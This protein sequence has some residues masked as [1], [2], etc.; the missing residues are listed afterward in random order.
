MREAIFENTKV[1]LTSDKAQ[2]IAEGR[3]VVFEGHLKVFDK[4]EEEKVLPAL[5]KGEK[6]ILSD[7]KVTEHTTKPPPRFND[8]SLVKLLEEKGIGRPSTYV[9]TIT[10]LLKRNYVK[11]EKGNFTPTELGIKVCD[12]LVSYFPEIIDEKFTALIEK[13]LDEVEESKAEWNEVLKE[14]YPSFKEKV[15]EASRLIK[16]EVEYSD[17]VCPKCNVPLVVKWSRK[18]K[19]LSC[20]NFPRCRYA[21]SITTEVVCPQCKEGKL[22]QRRNKRGQFFYGCTKFPKC[23]YTNRTLPHSQTNGQGPRTDD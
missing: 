8:A 10:T 7:C 14:F 16:K 17:R 13:R 15:D 21:E 20:V 12:I 22:I 2:F 23:R 4:R 3:R 19:F 6:V 18:G 11:R 1:I 9:P 5:K